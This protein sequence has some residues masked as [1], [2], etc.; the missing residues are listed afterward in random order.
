MTKEEADVA[1]WGKESTAAGAYQILYPTWYEAWKK[2]GVSDLSKSSQDK[3]AIEKLRSR[4]ALGY[5]EQDDIDHAIPLHVQG[6][7]FAA[8]RLAIE[9]DHGR[10]TCVICQIPERSCGQVMK[11]R[12]ASYGKRFA[13]R[14]RRHVARMGAAVRCVG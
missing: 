6:M 7:D 8:G 2:G 14:L 12:F 13:P 4:H 10:G 9:N 1:A 3:L 11:L 5:V